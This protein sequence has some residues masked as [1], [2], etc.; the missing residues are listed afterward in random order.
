M[1]W[2]IE[3]NVESILQW[4]RKAAKEGAGLAVFTECAITGYHRKMPQTVNLE[5]LQN[6][7]QK[8]GKC[9]TAN[10][11]AVIVGS[12]FIEA[13]SSEK[14]YNSA[15]YFNPT[16][17][18]YEI[19]SKLGLTKAELRFFTKGQK[20]GFFKVGGLNIGVVFCREIQDGKELIEDYQAA[21]LDLI[22]WPSYIKWDSEREL[23]EKDYLEAAIAISKKLNVPILNINSANSLNDLSLKGLGASVL[24]E[25][26]E[27]VFTL[28]GDEEE[29]KVIEV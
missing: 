20:R 1:Y 18:D 24:V 4:I 14:I 3:E 23:G 17:K 27:I 13:D 19:T 7:Y 22:L 11:I 9:A 28:V 25:N 2:R 10:N 16:S 8:I 5:D 12:P 15:I 6:A 21:N 29:L 26:G